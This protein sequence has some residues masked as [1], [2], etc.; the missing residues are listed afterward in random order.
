MT[1]DGSISKPHIAPKI[2]KPIIREHGVPDAGQQTLHRGRRA[3]PEFYGFAK[4]ARRKSGAS[5]RRCRYS[6]REFPLPDAASAPVGIA[7]GADGNLWFTEKVGNRIGRISL[8]GADRG[9]RGAAN[10]DAGPDGIALGPDG[11]VW[12]SEATPTVSGGSHRTGGIAEF[13]RASPPAASRSRSSR[14]EVRSG[15]ARQVAAASAADHLSGDVTEYPVPRP[16]SRSAR[17]GAASR[18][19][20][21][22]RRNRRQRARSHGAA[23]ARSS[24]LTSRRPTLPRA[25]LPRPPMATLWFTENFANKI[26]P[27]WPRTASMIAEYDYSGDQQ[28]AR[29]ALAAM[30]DGRLFFTQY[31]AGL[32]GEII[33]S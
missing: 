16:D 22:V 2:A 24:N 7:L 17:H 6:L 8:A 12:F 20:H 10:A 23:T 4:T 27:R 15:S 13:G 18:R 29:G 31:D 1:K 11:N 19:Q 21:L 3:R 30:A 26:G 14:A 25:A 9:V 32:I 28:A 5:I 33:P